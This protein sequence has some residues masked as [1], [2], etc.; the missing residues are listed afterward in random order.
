M[1]LLLP[2]LAFLSFPLERVGPYAVVDVVRIDGRGPFRF[3]LDTG[4]Q[5]FG[6]ARAP[7]IHLTLELGG[8]RLAGLEAAVLPRQN[9]AEDGLLPAS[10]FARIYVNHREGYLIL[11]PSVAGPSIA[12]AP[13]PR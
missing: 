9:R 11:N 13:P 2:L 8:I 4:A 6:S 10:L 7:L 12:P 1:H 5:S 3:L